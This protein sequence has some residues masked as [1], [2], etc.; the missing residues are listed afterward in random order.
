M[1]AAQRTL[2]DSGPIVALLEAEDNQWAELA[3]FCQ[4]P[5]KYATCSFDTA[6]SFTPLVF[7]EISS[8]RGEPAGLRRSA[9]RPIVRTCGAPDSLCGDV[10]FATSRCTTNA[11]GFAAGKWPGDSSVPGRA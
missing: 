5:T 1:A 4:Q 2:V 10:Q 8:V 9:A 6:A 3:R 11:G 7:E